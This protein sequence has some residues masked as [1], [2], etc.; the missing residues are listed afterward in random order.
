MI[1][2]VPY[3]LRYKCQPLENQ[4]PTVVVPSS[5]SAN[6]IGAIGNVHGSFDDHV[7]DRA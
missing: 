5:G 1:P 3:Y 6:G 2:L 4:P 7:F